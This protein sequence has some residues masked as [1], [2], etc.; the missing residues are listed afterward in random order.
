MSSTPLAPSASPLTKEVAP[1]ATSPTANSLVANDALVASIIEKMSRRTIAAHAADVLA[2]FRFQ[3]PYQLVGK[4]P[5]DLG[6]IV[7]KT[8]IT[9]RGTLAGPWAT[10]L[11]FSSP[12][13]AGGRSAEVAAVFLIRWCVTSIVQKHAEK[14]VAA[15]SVKAKP[16]PTT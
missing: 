3:A 7:R 5:D 6:E 9:P 4:D 14:V 13:I 10:L 12:L 11:S 8:L 15:K 1:K 16:A 2:D